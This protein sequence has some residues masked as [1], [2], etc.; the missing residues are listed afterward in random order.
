MLISEGLLR[1]LFHYGEGN[2][3]RQSLEFFKTKGMNPDIADFHP[4][5]CNEYNPDPRAEPTDVFSKF[6]LLQRLEAD[7][8]VSRVLAAQT[9]QEVFETV[10]DRVQEDFRHEL[11]SDAFAG[12]KTQEL[13]HSKEKNALNEEGQVNF[14]EVD[15]A[16]PFFERFGVPRNKKEEVLLKKRIMLNAKARLIKKAH[17][18]KDSF[19]M[20]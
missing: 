20:V 7:Q 5:D 3:S 1:I 16:T 17:G 13:I 15:F 6:K 9:E 8:R 2:I 10:S 14:D 12:E 18:I 19:E 11:D 4:E